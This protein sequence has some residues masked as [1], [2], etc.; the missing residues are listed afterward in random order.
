MDGKA[1]SLCQGSKKPAIG[2]EGLRWLLR[3]TTP[4]T[5]AS[6]MP[7]GL[8]YAL[9]SA[10]NALYPAIGLDTS[11]LF[12]NAPPSSTFSARH[13]ITRGPLKLHLLIPPLST[14]AAD[15]TCASLALPSLCIIHTGWAQSGHLV[16]AA[17]G[18]TV[19]SRPH[20]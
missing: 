7:L 19:S 6:P 20:S 12:P 17:Q 14:R 16:R 4:T 5:T 9:A 8:C 18:G 11:G 13:P 2:Q 15:A 10:W 3:A 1:T